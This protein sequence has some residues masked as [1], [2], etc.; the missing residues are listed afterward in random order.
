MTSSSQSDRDVIVSVTTGTNRSH[1]MFYRHRNNCDETTRTGRLTELAR[2]RTGGL[3]FIGLI[4]DVIV[5][6]VTNRDE[7]TRQPGL[8]MV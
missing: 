1:V 8:S 2:G 5:T 7:T 6:I 4:D 3:T